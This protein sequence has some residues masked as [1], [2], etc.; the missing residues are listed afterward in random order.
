MPV[1]SPPYPS[2]VATPPPPTPR[3][4]TGE[5]RESP[6]TGH[7]PPKSHAAPETQPPPA[8]KALHSASQAARPLHE[9]YAPP[10]ATP[11]PPLSQK[12]GTLPALRLGRRKAPL[13]S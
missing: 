11:A 3:T 8:S 2:P 5:I 4:V 13:H 9:P 12:R 10:R 1:S 6:A 7:L